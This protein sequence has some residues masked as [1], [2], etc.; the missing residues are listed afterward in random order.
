MSEP[1]GST[2]QIKIAATCDM[3]QSRSLSPLFITTDSKNTH[4]HIAYMCAILA[5]H[6]D[7]RPKTGPDSK[8][9]RSQ[10][11][12][13]IHDTRSGFRELGGAR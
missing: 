9:A 4:T 6:I 12:G 1:A 8:D 5:S 7:T 10:S 13:I 3:Y 2:A 11:W